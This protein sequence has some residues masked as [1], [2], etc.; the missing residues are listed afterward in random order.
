MLTTP[1]H[2]FGALLIST[3]GPELT[4]AINELEPVWLDNH[5]G[6]E[7]AKAFKDGLAANPIADRWVK[8]RDGATYTDDS[9]KLKKWGGFVNN[10]SPIAMYIYC[11][12]TQRTIS[13]S[14]A[15]GEKVDAKSKAARAEYNY[16]H[17]SIWNKMV[18]LTGY[19][20]R[21]CQF[22][23][24]DLYLFLLQARDN[25][26]NRIYPEFDIDAINPE[27]PKNTFNI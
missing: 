7:L 22:Q 17:C 23:K 11:V 3:K 26:G 13:V 15:E 2:F 24:G 21:S 20:D 4:N 19:Y 25:V 9:G 8:L 6:I 5:L 10:V 1:N 16:K 18:G 12:Q 14:T 27:S